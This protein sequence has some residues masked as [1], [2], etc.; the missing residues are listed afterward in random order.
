MVSSSVSTSLS[1]H[2][3]TNG[4]KF[5]LDILEFSFSKLSSFGCSFA[6]VFLYSK[7]SGDFI[8][9]LFV[10]AG[11][12]GGFSQVFV[13]LFKVHL[14]VH[15]LVLKVFDFLQDSIS[16]FGHHCQFGYCLCQSGIC[17]LCFFFHQHDTSAKCSDIF[18]GVLEFLLLFFICC[19]DLGQ[20]V[21]GFIKFYFICLDLLSQ[22]S[23]ITFMLV[24]L[25]VG[26]LYAILV[27]LDGSVQRVSL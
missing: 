2:V 18:L 8:E 10:V 4:F 1:F 7:L 3:F 14:V 9:L 13:S 27:L 22:I 11:H 19:Q 17:F 6:F 24:V 15:G 21:V 23:D 26:F 5:G 20:F 25:G 16:F 12:F